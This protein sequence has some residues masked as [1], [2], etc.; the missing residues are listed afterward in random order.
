MVRGSALLVRRRGGKGVLFRKRVLW[1]QLNERGHL[2][3]AGQTSFIQATFWSVE[4]G[5]D[6]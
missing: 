2:T 6:V 4:S 3:A 1:S 5:I